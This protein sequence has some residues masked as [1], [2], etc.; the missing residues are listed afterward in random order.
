MQYKIGKRYMWSPYA[1]GRIPYG[2]NH[3]Y[4]NGILK[5]IDVYGNGI[6][7]SLQNEDWIVPLENLI[8]Y[9]RS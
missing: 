1:S 9:K 6:L 4:V 7:T 8:E 2:K 5:E 3:M